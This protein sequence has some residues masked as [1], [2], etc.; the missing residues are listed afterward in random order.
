MS[1]HVRDVL[2]SA[3]DSAPAPRTSTDDII[4]RAGRIRTR[5]RL[6]AATGAGAACLAIAVAAVS[7]LG[8]APATRQAAGQSAAQP[9]GITLPAGFT[10]VF[11]DARAGEYRIGPAGEVTSGYQEVPV[12]REGAT[13]P[14]DDGKD[15]PLVDGMITVY[16]PGVY[17]PDSFRRAGSRTKLG[18]EFTV[19]VAG[20]PGVG[21]KVTYASAMVN[22]PGSPSASP[23][24]DPAGGFTRVALAWEYE[25]GAWA[26]YVPGDAQVNQSTEDA[27]A[28]AEALSVV[29]ERP[30]RA[31]YRF[32]YLPAGWQPIA[33]T[34]TDADLSTT[35]SELYLHDGPL[36]DKDRAA[37]VDEVTPRTVKIF[38]S[39]S[40]LKDEAIRGKK[41][42][43]C[44]EQ[45]VCTRVLG[46]Y[47]IQVDGMFSNALPATEV[48]KIAEG[49]KPVDV[50]DRDAWVP[51]K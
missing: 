2:E 34:E 41:G 47:F 13:W 9:G 21:H 5:R 32:G 29:P 16:R 49:L 18:P 4:A 51:V 44:Y 45:P 11:G 20:R 10:T 35:V 43:H 27:V 33:V 8:S 3:R 30:V 31:P 48:R 12:Y 23:S 37:V 46:D 25:P 26:T 24:F 22:M 6:A 36:A 50:T 17:D 14:G 39:R 1:Y 38:V 19:T 15:Y 42:V 40:T 28:V 7:G